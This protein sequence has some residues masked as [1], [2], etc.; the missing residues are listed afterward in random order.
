MRRNRFP[1]LVLLLIAGCSE[2]TPSDASDRDGGDPDAGDAG[3]GDAGEPQWPDATNTGI[4]D[5]ACPDGLRRATLTEIEPISN[6]VVECVLFNNG[7]PYVR[8][9]ASNVHFRY[10][11][12][13]T[14]RDVFVNLQ[15]GPVVI[16]DSE[17]DGP[18]GT[19]IRAVYEARGLVIR[20]CDFS[21]MANA[22]EFGT[23]DVVLEDNYV[24]DF[25][26]VDESQHADG[27]QTEGAKHFSI[28]HN[29]ILFNE[30]WG[31]TS[32]LLVAGTDHCVVK[33]NL[34]AGGG[35]TIH[36]AGDIAVTGNRVS[37]QFH[38][39]SGTYGAV[40][41][42]SLDANGRWEDNRWLDGPNV[43]KA[44]PAP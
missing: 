32:A 34:V 22:V 43:G 26:D 16:E 17:F 38:E 19:W 2:D 29:T 12:F 21:G 37:T 40:Y 5:G 9:E 6:A 31:S 10:C 7:V 8:Q 25:G 15:G 23:D 27:F 11:R 28:I 24:H 20:R 39:N 30:V 13:E 36:V 44:V 1:W 35:Y 4:P 41:P 14:T 42:E 3:A 33:D 18:A